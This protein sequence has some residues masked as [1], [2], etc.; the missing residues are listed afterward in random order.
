MFYQILSA[1]QTK[2]SLEETWKKHTE[3]ISYFLTILFYRKQE[4]KQILLPEMVN[5]FSQI[6]K[7]CL[8]TESIFSLW[9]LINFGSLGKRRN[10]VQ[11]AIFIKRS[12]KETTQKN[13]EEKQKLDS[14]KTILRRISGNVFSFPVPHSKIFLNHRYCKQIPI[15]FLIGYSSHR[16]WWFLTCGKK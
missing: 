12:K 8:T 14:D 2:E 13:P 10:S 15:Q 11:N 9:P 6:N 3:N 16:G 5:D 4:N 7:V 1:G